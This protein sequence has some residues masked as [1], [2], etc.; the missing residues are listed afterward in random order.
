[1]QYPINERCSKTLQ[2]GVTLP[3]FPLSLFVYRDARLTC[4]V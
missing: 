2:A 4:A 1:M 3:A